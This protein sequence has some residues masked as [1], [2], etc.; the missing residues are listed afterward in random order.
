MV[1]RHAANCFHELKARIDRLRTRSQRC[2]MMTTKRLT[3]CMNVF[4]QT[5]HLKM[6]VVN[7]VW[8]AVSLLFVVHSKETLAQ[9]VLNRL[10]GFDEPRVQAVATWIESPDDE[11]LG[12]EAA[13]LLYQVN[14]L[15]SVGLATEA[16]NVDQEAL[17]GE[18]ASIRGNAIR[19]DAW[20]LPDSLADVLEFKTVYRVEI[21]SGVQT[22]AA[23]SDSSQPSEQSPGVTHVI[24]TKVPVAW[25]RD[26]TPA[27]LRQTSATGVVIRQASEAQSAVIAAPA[28]SWLATSAADVPA[29]WAL[30]GSLGF[31]VALL[32]EVRKRDR[33]EL[34]VADSPAFYPLLRI[35]ASLGDSPS[36]TGVASLPSAAGLPAA[37]LL[38]QSIDLIGRRVKLE[39]QTVRVTRIAITEDVTRKRLG[40][41]HYWQIDAL[42]DLGNVVIRIESKEGDGAVFENRYPVSVAVRELPPFLKEAMT[43]G[44]GGASVEVAMVSRPVAVEGIYYRL[45]SYES[46]FM[47]QHGG[48][49]QFGPL[50]LA[51]RISP[52]GEA[53]IGGSGASGIGKY[54]AGFAIF[55]ILAAVFGSLYAA[56]RDAVAKKRARQT[57]PKAIGAEQSGE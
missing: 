11:Q 27:E 53:T 4:A 6:R 8:L 24:T 14:R 22:D 17:V 26:D 23:P 20:D 33:Q 36:A 38:K 54:V 1:S 44:N 30:L 52:L 40:S 32:E 19:V 28:L 16:D 39:L 9:S 7:V 41:D 57:L 21:M 49:N 25:L 37:D 13:K 3:R 34:R 29:D 5:F 42:G 43:E 48:G 12:T 2:E 10:S 35:A 15:A 56:R 55:G 51:S 31:D 50:I 18:M 45:W 46:D 47:K